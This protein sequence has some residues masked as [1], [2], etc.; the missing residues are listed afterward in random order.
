MVLVIRSP[1]ALNNCRTS[2]AVRSRPPFITS[3]HPAEGYFF[4]DHDVEKRRNALNRGSLMFP[5]ETCATLQSPRG[6]VRAENEKTG[7]GLGTQRL[8]CGKYREPQSHPRRNHA[9]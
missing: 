4:S 8:S 2:I 3:V 1:A 5:I 9:F 7:N 6:D